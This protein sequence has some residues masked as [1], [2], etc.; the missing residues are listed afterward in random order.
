MSNI[1]TLIEEMTLK[2]TL[3][4]GFDKESVYLFIKTL[5]SLH[6]EEVNKLNQEKEALEAEI[7]KLRQ[8][9]SQMNEETSQLK[10]RLEEE[11]Q[12]HHEFKERF[13]TLNKAVELVHDSKNWI[14]EDTQKTAAFILDQA[15]EQLDCVKQEC[16]FQQKRRDA[17]VSQITGAAKQ[18]DSSMEKLRSNLY[19]MLGDA[20]TLKQETGNDDDS[21]EITAEM[22]LCETA[23]ASQDR[24]DETVTIDKNVEDETVILSQDRENE[25]AA[26]SKDSQEEAAATVEYSEKLV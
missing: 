16:S 21:P 17:I 14:I 25:I 5:Y 20:E 19:S 22:D 24:E 10:Q 13:D 15:N 4:R 18:F 26:I 9:C 23:A 3:L 1:D 6:Q 11:Q 2:T 8:T 12:F 7:D